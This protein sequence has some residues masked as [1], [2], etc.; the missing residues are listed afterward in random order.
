VMEHIARA[1][2]SAGDWYPF[3]PALILPPNVLRYIEKLLTFEGRSLTNPLRAGESP[4]HLAATKHDHWGHD[5]ILDGTLTV[6]PIFR[7]HPDAPE[8]LGYGGVKEVLKSQLRELGFG[9]TNP[10]VLRSAGAIYWR[11]IQNMRED[12][13][14]T[15]GLWEDAEALRENYARLSEADKR[16]DMGAFIPIGASSVPQRLRGRREQLATA[17]IDVLSAMLRQPSSPHEAHRL[18]ADLQ[19]RCEEIDQ[20]IAADLGQKWEP[21]RRDP[22]EAGELQL[23]NDALRGAGYPQGIRGIIGRDLFA[24]D[25]L[26]SRAARRNDG[27][28]P[29]LP[30]IKRARTL[31]TVPVL[32]VP[33][34][35]ASTSRADG[36]VA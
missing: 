17:A 30:T 15:L 26:Q 20:T 25:A 5:P 11:F 19:H 14:M 3:V 1:K 33:A 23:I 36:K 2:N 24:S 7:K 27:A 31:R 8:G 22:F 29:L 34:K 9:A 16:A 21:F 32:A 28:Q 13:V 35:V 12:L 18:L 10:H 6:A 4:V